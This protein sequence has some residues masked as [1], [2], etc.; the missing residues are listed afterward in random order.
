M[1]IIIHVL[2]LAIVFVFIVLSINSAQGIPNR[3]EYLCRERGEMGTPFKI[4]AFVEKAQRTRYENDVQMAFSR[5]REM[6]SWMSEWRPE[7]ML[8][9]INQA[10]GLRAITVNNDLFE[11][12]SFSLQVSI[13]T[14]GAF[15]PTFNALWGLYNFKKGSYREATEKELKEKLPLIDYRQVIL[16]REKKTVFLKK[17]GMKLGLGGIGQ[18]YAVDVIGKMLKDR[19]YVAGFVDGSGDTLFW[20]KKPDGSLWKIGVRDPRDNSKL[21]GSIYGTDFA[22]TTCGDDNKFFM[23]GERRV[24]HVID[25][26]TGR[27]SQG[28]RQVTVIAKSAVVADAYDTAAFILGYKEGQRVL[29]KQGV[30]GIFVT[31]QKV[32]TTPGVRIVTTSWGSS[33]QVF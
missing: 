26:K 4:C 1:R 33:W 23:D 21:V 32:I 13:N 20:G 2:G 19:G 3:Y 12:L 9:Q 6:D 7:T 30:E 18:G 29:E 24:H 5:I 8:S 31:D 10:A 25:P 16:N 17:P 22:V 14:E 11:L 27:P 28:V 15:D